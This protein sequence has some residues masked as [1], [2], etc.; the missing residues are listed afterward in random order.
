M[1]C[2]DQTEELTLTLDEYDHIASF[3]LQKI[4]CGRTVGE[5]ILAPYVVGYSVE[6]ILSSTIEEVVPDLHTYKRIEEFLLFKQ[7]FSIR[8]ALLVLTGERSG[9]TSEPFV[10]EELCFDPDQTSLKGLVAVDL[11]SEE[12]KSCGSCKSCRVIPKKLEEQLSALS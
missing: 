8:A 6:H 7:Y 5:Q 10:V 12:I 9:Q 3:H 4:S 2:K 11:I 1:P